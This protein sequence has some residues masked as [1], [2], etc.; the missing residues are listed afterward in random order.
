[1]NE[2]AALCGLPKSRKSIKEL[3]SRYTLVES[4]KAN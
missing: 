1:M 4:E 3:V 2:H